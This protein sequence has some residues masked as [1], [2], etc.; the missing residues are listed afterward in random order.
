MH[1]SLAVLL[2]LVYEPLVAPVVLSETCKCPGNDTDV[3]FIAQYECKD[4]SSCP[5]TQTCQ[6]FENC[7]Q[8]N[9]SMADEV[10]HHSCET[11]RAGFSNSS[12]DCRT[13]N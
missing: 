8:C 3:T 12:Y 6:R 9:Y 11:C 5:V 2:F 10:D 7:M 1:S 13:G 4:T